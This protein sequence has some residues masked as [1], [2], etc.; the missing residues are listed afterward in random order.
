MAVVDLLG[1]RG[2]GAAARNAAFDHHHHR[3]ARLFIR[4]KGGEPGHVIHQCCR[5]AFFT[6]AVPVLPQMRSPGHRRLDARA[7][8]VFHVG[9]HGV[10]H[11]LQGARLTPKFV[12]HLAAGKQFGWPPEAG[13][14]GSMRSTRRGQRTLPPLAMAAVSTAIWS[15]VTAIGP[16]PMQRLPVS[17][18]SQPELTA[19]RLGKMPLHFLAGGQPGPFAEME[20][21]AE[22][23]I[24]AIPARARPW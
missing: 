17:P 10:V 2:A 20:P 11:D 16:C 12:P 15:G 4:R 3:V 7:V 18:S 8:R 13:S 1:D 6:W 5:C 14:G 23:T 24:F 19:C 21:L 9:Q 22:S